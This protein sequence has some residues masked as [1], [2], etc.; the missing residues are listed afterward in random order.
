MNAGLIG[1]KAGMMRVFETDG[2]AVPATV[3]TA[4]PCVVVCKKAEEKDGYKAVQL[5]FEIKKKNVNKPLAGQFRK[6]GVEPR[7]LLREFRV[8]NG[9]EYQVG[10]ELRVDMFSPGD[11]VD[12]EGIS[13]GKGFTGVMKRWGFSGGG[14]SHGANKCKRRPGSIGASATPGRVLKGKKMPGRAGMRKVSA[15]S[16]KVVRVDAGSNILMVK[17][18]VPGHVNSYVFIRKA[19]KK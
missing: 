1:K 15:Q 14:A 16:L 8:E 9:E 17:G 6:A 5:G 11:F 3:I 10:Q 18:A 12:V 19:K 13:K 2:T 4:G 7:R